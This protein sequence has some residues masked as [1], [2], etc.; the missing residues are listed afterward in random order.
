MHGNIYLKI[1]PGWILNNWLAWERNAKVHI[2]NDW[3][4]HTLAS[5]ILSILYCFKVV[6]FQHLYEI[7]RFIICITMDAFYTGLMNYQNPSLRRGLIH[8]KSL[9]VFHGYIC[10]NC[11]KIREISMLVIT[12]WVVSSVYWLSL[13]CCSSTLDNFGC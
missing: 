10:L 7:Q 6:F 3:F 5:G 9:H 4:R 11:Y 1:N 8:D 2:Q 12:R 13:C